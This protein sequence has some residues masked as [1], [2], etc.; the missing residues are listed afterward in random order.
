MSPEQFYPVDR[1]F[2]IGTTFC[3]FSESP[4][5]VQVGGA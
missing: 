1:S 3:I 5:V 4:F 2:V